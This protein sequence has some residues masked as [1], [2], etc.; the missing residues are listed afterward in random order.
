MKKWKPLDCTRFDLQKCRE[1]SKKKKPK[2]VYSSFF[3]SVF[4]ASFLVSLDGNPFKIT[5]IQCYT[6]TDSYKYIEII[7]FVRTLPDQK[8]IFTSYYFF[9]V[10]YSCILTVICRDAFVD[11][12]NHEW[13][14]TLRTIAMY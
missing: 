9:F 11:Y 8:I 1:Q 5:R 12:L 13:L 10:L 4:V 6:C 3:D 14:L 7:F 2:L